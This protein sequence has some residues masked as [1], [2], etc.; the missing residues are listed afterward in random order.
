MSSDFLISFHQKHFAGTDV[1]L[2]SKQV[3]YKLLEEINKI[4]EV[5]KNEEES[6]RKINKNF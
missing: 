6:R 4:K 2:Y 1:P 5:D 3:F